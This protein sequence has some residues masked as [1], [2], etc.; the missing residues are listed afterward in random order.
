[1]WL[2]IM[3][4]VSKGLFGKN[5]NNKVKHFFLFSFFQKKIVQKLEMSLFGYEMNGLFTECLTFHVIEPGTFL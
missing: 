1:M 3:P 5:V 2:S 4:E